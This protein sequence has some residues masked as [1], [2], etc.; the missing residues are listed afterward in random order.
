VGILGK[1]QRSRALAK[2]RRHARNVPS[3]ASFGALAERHVA[4]GQIDLALKTAEEGLAV[5]PNSERLAAVRLFAKKK[6]LTG[7]IRRLR[8]DLQRRPSPVAFTQL[9]EIYRELGDPEAALELAT[10]CSERFPL[11]ESPYLIQGEIR[12]ERFLSDGIAKDAII[13][14]KA[15]SKVVRLNGHNVKAHLFLAEV[16]NLVGALPKCRQHLRSVLAI[17]PGARDVQLFLKNL[18]SAEHETPGQKDFEE[19]ARAIEGGY[20][21]AADPFEFPSEHPYMGNRIRPQSSLSIDLESLKEEV[22]RLGTKPG[23]RNS[24]ILDRDGEFLADFTDANSL[25]RRQFCQLVNS[26]NNTADEASRRMD[27]GALVRAE[28]EGP[29]GSMTVT[30]VRTLTIAILYDDPLRPD[31]VWELLQDFIARNL[32]NR[33][34]VLVA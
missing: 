4:L 15:L 16:Y 9:A 2:L 31:R 19:L 18:P 12:L 10:E 5:F 17:V 24:I 23:V 11:N 33:K 25:S 27:T 28:I 8:D 6:R 13:A 32:T 1:L 7:Q 30:R 3:P 26:I 14:E 29:F 21:F 34:E 22:V 20:G